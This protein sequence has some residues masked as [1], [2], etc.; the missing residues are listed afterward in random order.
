MSTEIRKNYPYLITF[1]IV[2][3]VGVLLIASYALAQE[4]EEETDDGCRWQIESIMGEG[5]QNSHAVNTLF[6]NDCTGEILH[7]GRGDQQGDAWV[8]QGIQAAQ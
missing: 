5:V 6:W 8:L 7:L 4:A 1:G 3:L 2:A